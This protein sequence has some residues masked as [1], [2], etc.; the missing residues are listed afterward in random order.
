[1]PQVES[2]VI[3][4]SRIPDATPL[5]SVLVLEFL[6]FCVSCLYLCLYFSHNT[7]LVDLRCPPSSIL[8]ALRPHSLIAF[9]YLCL[10]LYL[11]LSHSPIAY[12]Y[13]CLY[14]YLYL[15]HSSIA[16]LYL[17]L[18]QKPKFIVLSSCLL[19]NCLPSNIPSQ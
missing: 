5:P 18:M 2:T 9:A 15:S 7:I 14:L 6:I 10:Y 1:M 11:Y 16:Y 3:N 19:V 8:L 13:L 17:C 4:G 12:L